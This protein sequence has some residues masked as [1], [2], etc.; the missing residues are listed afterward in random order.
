MAKAL[1]G[2]QMKKQV[3]TDVAGLKRVMEAG[4]K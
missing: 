1:A 4:T 2:K 3:S